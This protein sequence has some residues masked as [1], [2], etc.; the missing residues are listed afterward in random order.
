MYHLISY[1]NIKNDKFI[2]HGTKEEIEN[3]LEKKNSYL[4]FSIIKI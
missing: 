2:I 4:S 1:Y 3:F